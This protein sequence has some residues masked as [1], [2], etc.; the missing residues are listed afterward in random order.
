MYPRTAYGQFFG[1]II[2]AVLPKLELKGGRVVG[3]SGLKWSLK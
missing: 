1:I 2:L 3:S